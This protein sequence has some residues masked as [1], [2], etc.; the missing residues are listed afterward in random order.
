MAE[1]TK[2]AGCGATV[3]TGERFCPRCVQSLVGAERDAL[4]LR[5][6]RRQEALRRQKQ[7]LFALFV[8]LI[9]LGYFFL[10]P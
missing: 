6:L 7:I 5:E 8:I 9:M 10:R 3:A 1:T 4:Q 2:C